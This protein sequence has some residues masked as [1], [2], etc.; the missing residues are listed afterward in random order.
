MIAGGADH[1]IPAREN[2][3]PRKP[4]R[5]MHLLLRKDTILKIN[6]VKNIKSIN[7]LN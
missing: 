5:L 7:D 4:K 6:K 3:K 2:T 1:E